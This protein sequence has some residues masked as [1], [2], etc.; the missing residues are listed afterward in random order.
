MLPC[1]KLDRL[2]RS[3]IHLLSMTEALREW[4]VGSVSLRDAHIGTTTLSGRFMLQILGAVAELER[5]SSKSA[6]SRRP[7]VSE[8]TGIRKDTL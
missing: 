7:P 4:G 8:V 3:V 1:G 5:G 2:T 6:S